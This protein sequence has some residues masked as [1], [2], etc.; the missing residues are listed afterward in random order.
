[1]GTFVGDQQVEAIVRS[2]INLG[3]DLGLRVVAEGVEDS[4]TLARLEALGCDIAQG[5]HVARPM[6]PAELPAWVR[7]RDVPALRAA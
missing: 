3:H 1:M 5:W 4:H 2:T 6:P 7:D